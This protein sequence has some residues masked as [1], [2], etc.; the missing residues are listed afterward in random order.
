VSHL[1]SA[2]GTSFGWRHP[3]WVLANRWRALAGNLSPRALLRAMPRLLR[4]ELR[5]VRTL[6]R[7]NPRAL[8]VAV[9]VGC[10]LPMLIA[11]SWRRDTPGARLTALPGDAP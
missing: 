5:A 9:A 3:W 7:R 1:G 2:T 8:P 10:A 4:G 6:A 11:G